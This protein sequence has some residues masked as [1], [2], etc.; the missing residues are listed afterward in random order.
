MGALAPAAATGGTNCRHEE[1]Q[2]CYDRRLQLD[3]ACSGRTETRRRTLRFIV[4]LERSGLSVVW[5]GV[6]VCSGLSRAKWLRG[7]PLQDGTAVQSCCVLGRWTEDAPCADRCARHYCEE[8]RVRERAG[9]RLRCTSRS[10]RADRSAAAW[11]AGL[12]DTAELTGSCRA[13][14]SGAGRAVWGPTAGR[15]CLGS[16]LPPRRIVNV[17]GPC[18]EWIA[19]VRG[20]PFAAKP[21]AACS[22]AALLVIGSVALAVQSCTHFIGLHKFDCSLGLSSGP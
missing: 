14:E 22:T 5:Q 9:R 8:S 21:A 17:V 11:P 7:K 13:G 16:L 2:I 6:V 10:K 15:V 3:G 18:S 4:F 12:E 19:A 20:W 1:W